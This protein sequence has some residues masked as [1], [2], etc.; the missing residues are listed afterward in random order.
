MALGL[1]LS[2]VAQSSI[3]W[4]APAREES[5][6][7]QATYGA[8]S[9]LGT[10]VYSPFKMSFCIL[11][12]IASGVTYPVAGAKTAEK[13]VGTSCRG[14]WVI[15]PNVLRGVSGLSFLA[16]CPRPRPRPN[17]SVPVEGRAA[18]G[19]PSARTRTWG[20]SAASRP[21]GHDRQRVRAPR[22]HRTRGGAERG[23]GG[24]CGYHAPAGD[25][26]E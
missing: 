23:G 6:P 17:N 16:T 4:A 10:L 13:V 20:G 24:D 22:A 2:L 1:G 18:S 9:V 25:R 11:G 12:A 15:S 14:T 21:A 3:G 8:G 19:P 7:E 5:T 26:E